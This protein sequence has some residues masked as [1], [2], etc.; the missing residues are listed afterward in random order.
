MNE[1]INKHTI[2]DVLDDFLLT[3]SNSFKTETPSLRF[4]RESQGIVDNYYSI[5][6]EIYNEMISIKPT[7]YDTS[8]SYLIYP[9]RNYELKTDCFIK[10]VDINV[11]AGK[12]GSQYHGSYFVN[13]YDNVEMSQDFKLTNVRITIGISNNDLN[14][15]ES[16]N[17]FFLKMS[18]EL[19]HIFRFYNICISN[20]SYIAN[21]KELKAKYGNWIKLMMFGNESDDDYKM[22]S[23]L[24]SIDKNEILSDA[25]KLY[26][27]IR[28][29][30][31]INRNTFVNC[32]NDLPLYEK[33]KRV[34]AYISYID[35]ILY[36]KK[37]RNK[38]IELGLVYIKLCN[39]KDVS[40]EK[41]FMKL[42]F[43]MTSLYEYIRRIFLR[44]INKAF[45]DF[46]RK[47]EIYD[48]DAKE[49]IERNEHFNLLRELL[50]KH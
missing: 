26:E 25:N 16:K 27:F 47:N 1:F 11:L 15:R 21:E 23:S 29:N 28:Q 50:N 30:D 19:H 18:H 3:E 31:K 37:D 46:G 45:D 44:T 8:I 43:K 32:I 48:I 14:T 39:L 9:L 5:I 40:P 24:Y 22:A 17:E 49:I 13:D 38:E 34:E 41:A 6:D 12:K 10:S 2:Y 36:N 7:P 4:L 35:D 33:L 20:N 42:K